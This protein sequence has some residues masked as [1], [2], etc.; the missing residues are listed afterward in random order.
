MSEELKGIKN[1]I[2]ILFELLNEGNKRLFISLYG[3]PIHLKWDLIMILRE[4]ESNL[5][6]LFEPQFEDV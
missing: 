3:H 6:E 4:L 2:I 1:K 5:F